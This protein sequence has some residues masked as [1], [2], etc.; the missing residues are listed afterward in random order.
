MDADSHQYTAGPLVSKLQ[1]EL[2]QHE[3][4]ISSQR[5]Y[6]AVFTV[7]RFRN[8]SREADWKSTLRIRNCNVCI[9]ITSGQIS[10]RPKL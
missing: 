3:D 6:R 5:L 1:A 2:D 4:L 8:L 7:D 10:T 9:P